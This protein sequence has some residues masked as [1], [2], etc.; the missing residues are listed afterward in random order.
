M[1][2][3]PPTGKS[4]A[5][6][7]IDVVTADDQGRFSPDEK[8]RISLTSTPRPTSSARYLGESDEC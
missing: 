5:V 2:G 1:P 6:E 3:V 7:A 4:Y 8:C